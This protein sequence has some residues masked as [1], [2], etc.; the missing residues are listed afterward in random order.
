MKSLLR[1][2]LPLVCLLLSGTA[3]FA[4]PISIKAILKDATSGDPVSFATVS[5][6]REGAP[7]ADKYSLSSETG[8]VRVDGVRPG[9]TP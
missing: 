9:N 2:L 7:K 1:G 3:A 8:A 4:Q 5:L 6:T